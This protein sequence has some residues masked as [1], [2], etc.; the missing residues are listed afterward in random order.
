MTNVELTGLRNSHLAD[1]PGR[2][3]F[4]RALQRNAR[5]KD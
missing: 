5:K 2:R 1:H 3:S 4:E